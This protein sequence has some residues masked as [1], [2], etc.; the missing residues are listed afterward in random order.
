MA[1]FAKG[2]LLDQ[3]DGLKELN[4]VDLQVG[5]RPGHGYGGAESLDLLAGDPD[6]GL[7]GNDVAHVLGLGHGPVA[8]LD[9][10][11]DVGWDPGLHVRECLSLA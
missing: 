4:L 3:L 10:S 9:D 6:H 1:S 8:A 11:L 2:P 7:A 5:V